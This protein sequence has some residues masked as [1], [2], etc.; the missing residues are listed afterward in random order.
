MNKQ[1]DLEEGETK[2]LCPFCKNDTFFRTRTEEPC[3]VWMIDDGESVRDEDIDMC[4]TEYTYVCA[5]C[6]KDV[7]EEEMEK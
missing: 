5:K 7:T 2:L 4:V 6:D 1:P 3:K